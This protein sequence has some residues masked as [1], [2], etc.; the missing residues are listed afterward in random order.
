MRGDTTTLRATKLGPSVVPAGVPDRLQR[1]VV[2]LVGPK[3]RGVYS[4]TVD[5][6]KVKTWIA[7]NFGS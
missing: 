4:C 1:I 2:C 3:R 5:L 6:P 7:N